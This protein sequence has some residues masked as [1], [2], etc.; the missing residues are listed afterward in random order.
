MSRAAALA[1]RKKTQKG[2]RSEKRGYEEMKSALGIDKTIEKAMKGDTVICIGCAATTEGPKTACECATRR[3]PPGDA[4]YKSTDEDTLR[5]LVTACRARHKLKQESKKKANLNEQNAMTGMRDKQRQAKDVFD[6]NEELHPIDD[7]EIYTSIEFAVGKL[8]MDLAKNCVVSVSGAGELGVAAGWVVH[9]VDGTSIPNN[10]ESY[11]ADSKKIIQKAVM[12]SFKAGGPAKI[13]FRAP[14]AEGEAI[15][16]HM[17]D[18]FLPIGDWSDEQ[19]A[20]PPGKRMC[21]SCEM[22]ADF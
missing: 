18:K 10:E 21:E 5:A 20:K 7:T 3:P 6:P 17:C 1:A 14:A 9:E 22:E 15:Y 11:G 8:G 16:C 19:K 12:K 4:T 13:K 2:D